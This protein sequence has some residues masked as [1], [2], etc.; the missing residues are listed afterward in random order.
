MYKYS[1]VSDYLA[2]MKLG[3]IEIGKQFHEGLFFLKAIHQNLF[4]NP[5]P[6]VED[7]T[8]HIR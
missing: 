7:K 5:K 4:A 8:S 6:T 3:K 2:V 1:F